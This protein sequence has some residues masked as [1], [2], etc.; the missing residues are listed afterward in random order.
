MLVQS[1][2]GDEDVISMKITGQ[3]GIWV[4][5]VTKNLVAG[6]WKSV[7]ILGIEGTL[8]LLPLLHLL[9]DFIVMV[10]EPREVTINNSYS[11]LSDVR[12]FI[13]LHLC[14]SLG[15]IVIEI[16]QILSESWARL[17]TIPF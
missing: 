8:F 4:V 14:E 13:I 6:Q 1:S 16:I 11:N 2:G 12:L 15:H 5:N 17:G 10:Q 9:P 3:A 7:V